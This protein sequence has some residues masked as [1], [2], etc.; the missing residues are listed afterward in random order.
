MTGFE[1]A[2]RHRLAALPAERTALESLWREDRITE[3]THRPLQHLLG[4]EESLLTGQGGRK[5]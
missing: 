1:H 4:Y 2:G 5:A 3:E